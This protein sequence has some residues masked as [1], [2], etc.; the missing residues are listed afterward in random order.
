MF[1]THRGS[2]LLAPL[3]HRNS[4]QMALTL[5]R[6]TH[7]ISLLLRWKNSL[8]WC[9]ISPEQ[10]ALCRSSSS[11][12]HI[13]L[14]WCRAVTCRNTGNDLMSHQKQCSAFNREIMVIFKKLTPDMLDAAAV[15]IK[16]CWISF[17][18]LTL[19]TDEDW[20]T[21]YRALLEKEHKKRINENQNKN[22]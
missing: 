10:F 9:Q 6:V 22:R 18:C 12:T 5:S 14:L 20:V 4:S 21:C 1:C 15:I 17:T 13:L 19:Y 3:H 8:S 16:Y 7:L 2:D 11:W